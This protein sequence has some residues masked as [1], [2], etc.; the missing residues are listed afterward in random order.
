MIII[1]HESIKISKDLDKHARIEGAKK[2]F[3]D[4][5]NLRYKRYKRF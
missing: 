1:L 3:N 4:D 5:K 2:H